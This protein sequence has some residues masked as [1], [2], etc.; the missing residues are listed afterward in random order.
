MKNYFCILRC[1]SLS[2]FLFSCASSAASPLQ[3]DISAGYT[4]DN[5]VT[6][7]ELDSDIEKDS[8][9][10]LDASTRYKIPVNQ[11]SYFS[12]KGT[13]ELNKYL[14]FT[15]LS[16][17]R[18]GIHGSYHIRPS[19]GYTAT[20]YFLLAAYERRF[21]ESDQRDGSAT[22]LQLGL[23]KRLT[24]TV[25]L[26]GGFIKEDIDSAESIGVFDADNNRFYLNADFKLGPKN[27]LYTAL[28]YT[29][30]DIVSTTVP[31]QNIVNASRPF[32]VRDDAFL[33]LTPARFAYKLSAKT[34]A[35]TVGDTYSIKSNQALDASLFYYKSAAVYDIDYTGLIANLNYIYRF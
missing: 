33:D 18:L 2:A 28:S 31:N 3:T 6:R 16:N 30:G 34:T 12:I 8:I 26:Y 9:L 11:Q 1:L 19:N 27:T 29:D 25:T 32:I 35:I 7:A 14:D 10:N 20:R 21:F 15:K 13:L 24:D 4:Y 5:N 17:N 23:S 22:R